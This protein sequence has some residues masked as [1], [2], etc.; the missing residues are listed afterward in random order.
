MGGGCSSESDMTLQSGSELKKEGQVFVPPHTD[1]SLDTNCLRVKS[2]TQDEVAPFSQGQ[3]LARNSAM[4]CQ[5]PT[6]LG[7]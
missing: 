2:V 1:Q 6:A 5:E 7:S 3:V 4:G